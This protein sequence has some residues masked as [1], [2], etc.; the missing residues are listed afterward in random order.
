MRISFKKN[1]LPASAFLAGFALMVIELTA[2]RIIAPLVGSS[3]YTWTAVIGIIMLGLAIGN[4]LGGRIIDKYES[5]KTLF[6]FYL[7]SAASVVIIPAL[8][9]KMKAIVLL[10]MPLPLIII[11]ITILL[12]LIPSIC[13]G[14]IYPCIFKFYL[15]EMLAVGKKA[16]IISG[17]YTFGSIVGTFLTG[18][19]FISNIG[20]T[21][22]IF[23]MAL[24]LLCNSL[25][26]YLPREKYHPLM[27]AAILLLLIFSNNKAIKKTD[28]LIYQKES[29]YYNI[30]I[31]DKRDSEFG[32]ARLMFL[33]FD[34]HSVESLEN[35][36][37]DIY[38]NIPPA[39]SLL[40][41]KISDILVIGG[42]SQAISKNFSAYYKDS[43][44]RT[45][46][47]DPVVKQ[48]AEKYFSKEAGTGKTEIADGRMFLVRSTSS[49]DIIFNDAY[50]S[51]VSIPWHL[52]TKEFNNLALSRLNE[53]GIYAINFIS[54]REGDNSLF[55][56][57]MLKTFSK[58]F[59]NHYVFAYGKNPTETQNIILIGVNS[60][61]HIPEIELRKKLL[62]TKDTSIFTQ[63]L[64]I[65][66]L[67]LLTNQ[68]L[69]ILTDNYAP[70]EKLMSPIVSAHF[71]V[72]ASFYYSLF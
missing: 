49:Y 50:N 14:C 46:E 45:V 37:L 68:A 23:A 25:F 69:P 10:N 61:Q 55:F 43:A 40:K 59:P 60:D 19:F 53:D 8:S 32:N 31:I 65:K 11:S 26:F 15:K 38:T 56:Q 24:L 41:E 57:S 51:F 34:S 17:S 5:K 54:A 21:N 28:G 29:A 13:L 18:F 27:I 3:V 42:G 30:K 66:P 2:S 6:Y 4:I 35:K 58:T 1:L 52:S 63:K 62:E 72:F 71:P 70:T 7:L 16:G 64:L 39:F 9:V 47:I 67:A 20:S 12:F 44:V 48:A 33:D 22:T 36:S